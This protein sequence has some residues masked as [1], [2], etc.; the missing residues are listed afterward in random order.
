MREKEQVDK[1]GTALLITVWFFHYI[2]TI[3]KNDT[4]G[5]RVLYHQNSQR[6]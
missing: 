4:T 2:M 5:L 6:A 3:T 1:P